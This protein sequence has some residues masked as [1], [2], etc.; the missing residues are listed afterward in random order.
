M[1]GIEGIS[2]GSYS[3]CYM[4]EYY[5]GVSINFATDSEIE[6]IINSPEYSQMASYP[7]YGCIRNIN[8]VF[9]IKLSE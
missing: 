2:P 5:N 7:N 3:L 6:N 4:F 1:M 8:G 9:V